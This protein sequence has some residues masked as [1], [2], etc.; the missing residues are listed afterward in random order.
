MKIVALMGS[1]RG[2][3]GNT[4]R[5]LEELVAGVEEE[6]GTVEVIP[7]A[8]KTLRPCVA[9]DC[10][11]VQGECPVDDDFREI[12]AKVEASDA[13]VLASPNY[14]CSVTAQMKAFMDRCGGAIH[15]QSLEGKYG[16]ALETSGG[17]E[18]EEVLDYLERFVGLLGANSVGSVGSPVVGWRTFPLEEELFSRARELGRELCRS[19]REKR[20][21]PE[22]E[23]TRLLFSARMKD[24]VEMMSD[25]WTY[26]N[27]YWRDV[28]KGRLSLKQ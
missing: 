1:P 5:L 10:C 14:I 20:D 2:M 22:Q 12:F 28:R 8:E 13:F 16:A 3:K 23:K 24:L 26:E 6:G 17:G 9:C 11:H 7:L 21:F 25:F 18:D 4:G 19:A 15:C 27:E